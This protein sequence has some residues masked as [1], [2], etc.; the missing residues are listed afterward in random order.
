MPMETSTKEI[1][2]MVK[3]TDLEAI[4]KMMAFHT[5]GILKMITFMVKVS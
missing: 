5:W 4:L 2:K 3:K 1:S